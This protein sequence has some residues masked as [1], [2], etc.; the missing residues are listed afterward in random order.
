MCLNKYY[1]AEYEISYVCKVCIYTQIR[2]LLFTVPT[3]YYFLERGGG[4]K[5]ILPHKWLELFYPSL[6]RRRSFA[7]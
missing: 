7:G 5:V 1:I 2:A 4:G 6:Q 3:S